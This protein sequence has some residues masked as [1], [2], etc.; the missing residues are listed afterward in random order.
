MS[1]RAAGSHCPDCDSTS[2]RDFLRT[3]AAGVVGAGAAMYGVGVPRIASAAVA[4][5]S[6]PET[7]VAQFY[8]SLSEGQRK[9]I[10][11]PFDHE[12]RSKVNNNWFIVKPRI[13][14]FLNADQRQMVR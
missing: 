3:T 12:L 8:N 9:E 6:P 1:H 10:C 4:T 7:L 5:A 13:A 11:F 14:T 2:R